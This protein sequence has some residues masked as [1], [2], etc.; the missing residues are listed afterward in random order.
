M[1]Q[2]ATRVSEEEKQELEKYCQEHDI[3]ISQLIRW[4]IKEYINSDKN[5]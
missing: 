1:A 4:A 5:A 3:K 2:I